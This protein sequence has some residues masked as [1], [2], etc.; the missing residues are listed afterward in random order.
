MPDGHA[1]REEPRVGRGLLIADRHDGPVANRAGSLPGAGALVGEERDMDLGDTAIFEGAN[2]LGCLEAYGT[3][4]VVHIVALVLDGG[5]DNRS[6]S[7]VVPCAY[8]TSLPLLCD[9]CHTFGE[10][11][12]EIS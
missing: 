3:G 4:P 5:H 2:L 10:N 1:V 8:K 6:P 7:Y 9:G 12:W 11:F